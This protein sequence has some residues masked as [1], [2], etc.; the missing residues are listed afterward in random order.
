[1]TVEV[2]S[3]R[4]SKFLI[5]DFYRP[6]S[7]NGEYSLELKQSLSNELLNSTLLFPCGDFNF[8][9]INW[10]YQAAPGLNNLPNMFCDIVTDTLLIQMNH[11]PTK[12][13]DNTENILDLVLLINP[14]VNVEWRHLIANSPR[15]ILESLSSLRPK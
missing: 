15:T 12:I 4:A 5:Y 14:N 2:T 9:E 11:S 8:P 7:T 6:P 1:M 13:T 10:N 3:A